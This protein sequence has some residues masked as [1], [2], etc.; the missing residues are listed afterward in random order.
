MAAIGIEG[1]GGILFIVGS[2][3]ATYVLVCLSF[4]VPQLDSDYGSIP[5]FFC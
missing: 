2:N 3:L 4:N 1:I 5:A